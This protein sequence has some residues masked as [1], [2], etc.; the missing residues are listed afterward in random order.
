MSDTLQLREARD[1]LSRGEFHSAAASFGSLLEKNPDDFDCIT[2]F[3]I[4]KWWN[5][6]KES[7]ELRKPGRDLAIYLLNE[8][9]EFEVVANERQYQDCEIMPVIRDVILGRAADH[10]RQSYQNEGGSVV[11]DDLLLQLSRCLLRLGDN[12]NAADVLLFASNQFSQ[13]PAFLF[14]LAESFS[15]L[16]NKKSMLKGW[17]YYR[18]ACLI[19]H[20]QLQPDL[21]ESSPAKSTYQNL[22]N[23]LEGD[24]P[25]AL[26]W[27]P[28]WFM[29]TIF[30]EPI[31]QISENDFQYVLSERNRLSDQ[32]NSVKSQYKENLVA[33]LSFLLILILKDCPD[34]EFEY[35]H[36]QLGDISAELA[37]IC[38]QRN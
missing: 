8:W 19:D 35:F 38:S 1:Q 22:L 34:S 10:F 27:F 17:S 26:Q 15:R 31:S 36:K 33:Y 20:R 13:D 29:A 12:E 7:M 28:A 21:I 6:R 16:P 37:E 23:K 11:S 5:N 3:Y 32:I 18:S 4:S 24:Q 2:G 30:T 14:M 25:L 9:E